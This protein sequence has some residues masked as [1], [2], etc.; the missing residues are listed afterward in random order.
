MTGYEDHQSPLLA[1]LEELNKYK[2]VIAPR[3]AS[4]AAMERL[5]AERAEADLAECRRLLRSW[6]DPNRHGYTNE[7]ET[8]KYLAAIDAGAAG[9]GGE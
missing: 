2:T 1:T 5:R 6:L 3:L 9:R 7:A 8:E 4:E